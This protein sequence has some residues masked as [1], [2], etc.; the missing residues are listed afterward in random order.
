MFG[1]H[2]L[3]TQFIKIADRKIH[4]VEDRGGLVRYRRDSIERLIKGTDVVLRLLPAPAVGYG[5]SLLTVKLKEE[6]V[7]PPRG[8]LSGFLDVPVEVE[9]KV[10]N[11][12]ID[13]FI[14]GREK[15]ALYGPIENGVI[16]RYH[17]SPFYVDE[18]ETMGITKVILSNPTKE[19]KDL[20]RVVLPIGGSTMYYNGDRA[21]YPLILITLKYH[22]PEVNNTG[23]APREGLFRVG[24]GTPLPNFPMRW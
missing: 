9:V 5:V 18:P 17:V 12:S 22:S 20:D 7:V 8:S 6:V 10:G 2:R 13:H 24:N 21:Y 3:K 16:T 15:Y 1:E 14:V 19:W 23:K 11:L 4:L